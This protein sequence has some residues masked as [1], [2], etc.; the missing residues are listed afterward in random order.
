[1]KR[2]TISLMTLAAL[3]G[4]AGCSTMDPNAVAGLQMATQF[5][6]AAAGIYQTAQSGRQAGSA[7]RLN[8][9]QAAFYRAQARAMAVPPVPQ[10]PI[11]RG[12]R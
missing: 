3:G 7:V 9:A 2:L 6:G 12:Y 4:Q 10:Y 8:D 5:V 11:D 1:M